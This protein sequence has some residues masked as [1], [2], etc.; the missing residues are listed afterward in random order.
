MQKRQVGFLGRERKRRNLGHGL[1]E[2]CL[3]T[4]KKLEIQYRA[5]VTESCDR[6]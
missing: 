2:G 6:T 5:K 4:L 1:C 3:E